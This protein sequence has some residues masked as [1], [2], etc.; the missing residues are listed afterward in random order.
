[1]TIVFRRKS[2]EDSSS[3]FKDTRRRRV[4]SLKRTVLSKRLLPLSRSAL[5]FSII[6]NG[7]L[8][9]RA[10]HHAFDLLNQEQ[11]TRELLFAIG[12]NKRVKKKSIHIRRRLREV[13]LVHTGK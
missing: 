1:M 5:H 8:G 2:F 3:S 6:T 10:N 11:E 12:G 13:T 9:R 4:S 7:K